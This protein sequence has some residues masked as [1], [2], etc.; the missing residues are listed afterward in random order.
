MRKP[1]YGFERRTRKLDKQAK[2]A[3][4]AEAKRQKAKDG[5]PDAADG[6]ASDDQETQ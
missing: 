6:A 5:D 1:N 2:K 3:A 4:K